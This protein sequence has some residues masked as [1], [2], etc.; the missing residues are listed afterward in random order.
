MTET[1]IIPRRFN[2]PPTSA[3][4]G[5]ACGLLAAR[6][7]GPARV[8]LHSPPPLDTPMSI[9]AD[10]EGGVVLMWEDRLVASAWPSE[11]PGPVPEAPGPDAAADASTRFPGFRR[12]IYPGCFVCGIS[13]QPADGLELHPGPVRNWRLL[14]CVWRPAA[15]LLDET[16]HIRKEILWA[17]LDCP[18]YFGAVG[19]AVP[20]A[21]LGELT[22]EIR[23]PVP[24]SEPLLV[25]SWPVSLEG[26]KL[27]G[28]A[29]IAS[30]DGE[31]MAAARSTWIVVG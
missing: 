12:H 11:P 30:E 19:E 29:A 22:V 7:E 6:I 13:R 17:A 8:R 9:A 21:L 28:G 15:D 20:N 23:R 2:G 31:V 3:N 24:G 16:G 5:Y 27:F 1:I 14:A 26:R 10:A 18:A 25:Y 4:G